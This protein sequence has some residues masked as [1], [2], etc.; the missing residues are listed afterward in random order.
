MSSM[1]C[2]YMYMICTYLYIH[3]V[4]VFCAVICRKV[5]RLKVHFFWVRTLTAQGRDRAL[6]STIQELSWAVGFSAV[7]GT[8]W[9]MSPGSGF[10]VSSMRRWLLWVHPALTFS[11]L[12]AGVLKE[13]DISSTSWPSCSVLCSKWPFFCLGE[14]KG[15]ASPKGNCQ[16][17]C[18][19]AT[20]EATGGGIKSKA[21]ARR[22]HPAQHSVHGKGNSIFL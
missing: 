21:V 3:A 4:G 7:S 11:F 20:A 15:Q 19:G 2:V 5:S 17:P 1:T 18:D 10:L 12:A 14:R 16:R 13:Q 6:E 22:S 9:W 8:T